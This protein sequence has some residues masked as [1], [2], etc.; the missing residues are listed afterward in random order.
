MSWDERGWGSLAGDALVIAAPRHLTRYGKG[1]MQL[2][3][4][5]FI[6]S[7]TELNNP[8]AI[9]TVNKK[10]KH[11]NTHPTKANPLYAPVQISPDPAQTRHAP[12]FDPMKGSQ[13]QT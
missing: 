12:S 3:F 7:R 2:R 13:L 10:T 9:Y 4:S 1:T 8:Q 5:I 11:T 6:Y